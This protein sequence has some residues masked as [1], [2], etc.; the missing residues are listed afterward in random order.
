[1]GRPPDRV[2]S[3][4][5]AAPEGFAGEDRPVAEPGLVLIRLARATPWG[6][7]QAELKHLVG[8]RAVTRASLRHVSPAGWVVGV[9]TSESIEP[10]PGPNGVQRSSPARAG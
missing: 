7:V 2:A 1:M 8:A 10:P 9:A 4:E 5:L 6:L 3:A